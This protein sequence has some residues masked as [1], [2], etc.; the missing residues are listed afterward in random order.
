MLAGFGACSMSA[1]ASMN[2]APRS[3]PSHSNSATEG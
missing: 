3:R 1:V 2:L